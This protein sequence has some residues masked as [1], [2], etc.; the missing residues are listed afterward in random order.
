MFWINHHFKE[1]EKNEDA[2]DNVTQPPMNLCTELS[3]YWKMS[4]DNISFSK[5]EQVNSDMYSYGT[6]IKC[7]SGCQNALLL[8]FSPKGME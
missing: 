7:N 6:G 3:D 5:L 1:I 4:S 2:A 8:S